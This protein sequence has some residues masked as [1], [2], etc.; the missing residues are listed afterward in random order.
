MSRWRLACS[1]GP[2]AESCQH[3]RNPPSLQTHVVDENRPPL[4][5]SKLDPSEV[6]F[7]IDGERET[8]PR[9]RQTSKERQLLAAVRIDTPDKKGPAEL[10]EAALANNSSGPVAKLSDPT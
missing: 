4:A 10:R 7:P 9:G 5:S 8:L 6:L 3:Q 1:P 2:P